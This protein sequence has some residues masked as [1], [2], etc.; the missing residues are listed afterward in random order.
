[1]ASLSASSRHAGPPEAPRG[2]QR[3]AVTFRMSLNKGAQG[4]RRE[5][6]MVKDTLQTMI[7]QLQPA[8]EAG[9]REAAASCA[10]AG[11]LDA[12]PEACGAGEAG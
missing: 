12:P 9:E 7:L 8:K 1:M 11:A 10:T 5:L 6:Q 3:V 2:L 4:L